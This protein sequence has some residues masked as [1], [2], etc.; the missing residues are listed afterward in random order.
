[1]TLPNSIRVRLGALAAIA[2]LQ[3]CSPGG[4]SDE[5][6]SPAVDQNL[7]VADVET[8]LSQAIAEAIARGIS[9]T[10]AIVD[11]VGNVLA[12]FRMDGAA[13]T[14]TITSGGVVTTGL[15]G[16]VVPDTLAAISPV[17]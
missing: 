15:E 3:G 12:V 13:T 8:V 7:T 10:I 6:N 4:G 2:C 17:R 9:G 5:N 11:R 16:L 1:M 14:A